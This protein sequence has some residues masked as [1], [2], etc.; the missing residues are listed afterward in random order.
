MGP[1]DCG[2]Y[3]RSVDMEPERSDEGRRLYIGLKTLSVKNAGLRSSE[4]V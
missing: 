2:E 1:N 4:R 3:S